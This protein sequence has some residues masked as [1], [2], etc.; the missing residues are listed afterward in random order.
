ME[1]PPKLMNFEA[2]S[3]NMFENRSLR[4]DTNSQYTQFKKQEGLNDI[5]MM[6]Q[7]DQLKKLTI[8]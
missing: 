3:K 5:E 8:D 4:T 1:P 6:I 2:F 7:L